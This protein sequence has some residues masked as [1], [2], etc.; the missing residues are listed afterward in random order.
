[1]ASFQSQILPL[2]PN[3]YLELF[4]LVSSF[5]LVFFTHLYLETCMI[6]RN[7]NVKNMKHQ[8]IFPKLMYN[9]YSFKSKMFVL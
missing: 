4:G 2:D 9:F 6:L 5:L 1:M 8:K 7:N 3:T